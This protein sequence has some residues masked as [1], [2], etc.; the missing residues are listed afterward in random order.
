VC[1]DPLASIPQGKNWNSEPQAGFQEVV[2]E[3]TEGTPNEL[4]GLEREGDIVRSEVMV[5]AGI[6][7][8]SVEVYAFFLFHEIVKRNHRRSKLVPY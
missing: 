4:E 6:S 8:S 3:N 1:S 2:P 5:G 7:I